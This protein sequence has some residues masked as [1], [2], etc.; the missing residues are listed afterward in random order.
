MIYA[1]VSVLPQVLSQVT[2]LGGMNCTCEM[3][4]KSAPVANFM[5]LF[6]CNLSPY[7]HFVLSFD[8]GYTARGVNYLCKRL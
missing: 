6:C 4:M 3:F 8:S 5:K 7:Q 1:P 2:L